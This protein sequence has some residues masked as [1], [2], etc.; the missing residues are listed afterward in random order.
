M[1]FFT[2][3]HPLSLSGSPERSYWDKSFKGKKG[4]K[5]ALS[6]QPLVLFHNVML[7]DDRAGCSSQRQPFLL[8]L[9]NVL[10]HRSAGGSSPCRRGLHSVII[11]CQ[12]VT[13]WPPNIRVQQEFV[14]NVCIHKPYEEKCFISQGSALQVNNIRRSGRILIIN[15]EEM[16]LSQRCED[17]K[18]KGL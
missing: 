6:H 3:L 7:N 11:E 2:T 9:Q 8:K 12:H 10:F 13:V 15:R 17:V 4:Y 14:L 16:M 1:A 5:C 18:L